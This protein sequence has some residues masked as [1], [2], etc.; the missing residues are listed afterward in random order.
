MVP[1][2]TVFPLDSVR[3][4]LGRLTGTNTAALKELVNAAYEVAG[5]ALGQIF[6]G[7]LVVGASS[8]PDLPTA[9][10]AVKSLCTAE[11]TAAVAVYSDPAVVTSLNIDWKK[12]LGLVLKLLPLL[13]AE[14]Q[15]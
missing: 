2:P 8:L 14:N 15:S 6:G 4:L 7:P 11:F 1:Y 10:D 13:L 5:Y 9:D 12:W 3:L